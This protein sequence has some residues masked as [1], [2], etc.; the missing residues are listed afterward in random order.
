MLMMNYT[1]SYAAFFSI[2]A[3]V[4]VSFLRPES[5]LKLN[6][7]INAL[8]SGAKQGLSVAIACAVVGIVAVSYTHLSVSPKGGY[9]E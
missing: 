7:L 3:L 2:L 4:L 8:E 9:T 6:K 1:A 5:R